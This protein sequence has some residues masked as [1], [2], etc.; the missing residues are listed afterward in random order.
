MER[1]GFGNV[2]RAYKVRRACCGTQRCSAGWRSL[3]GRRR[4]CG[5]LRA[6]GMRGPA[7]VG[8][9]DVGGDGRRA[10]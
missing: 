5:W 2:A 6:G 10:R 8:A 4:G 3:G 9:A 1:G 7:R